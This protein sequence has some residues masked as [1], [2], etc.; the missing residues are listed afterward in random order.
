M[1][2]FKY[3]FDVQLLPIEFDSYFS[4]PILD[5]KAEVK[6][7]P[8]TKVKYTPSIMEASSIEFK[9]TKYNN[10]SHSNQNKKRKY[11]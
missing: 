4:N 11:K 6:Q 2:S 1:E 10:K 9:R 8:I 3:Y 7:R 5:Q